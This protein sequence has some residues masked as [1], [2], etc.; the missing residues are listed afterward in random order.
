MRILLFI[1]CACTS[2]GV[3]AQFH[4]LVIDASS[5]QPLAHVRVEIHET[6][7]QVLTDVKGYFVFDAIPPGTYHVHFF[8]EG[9]TPEERHVHVAVSN[10]SIS[11]LRI[12][13]T[14]MHF[15]VQ[16]VVVE[17]R[18]GK[19]EE[20]RS[21]QSVHVFSRDEIQFQNGI[22]LAER[23]AN[24]PGIRAISTG[25]GM[26][27]PQIRAYSGYRNAVYEYGLKHEAQQWGTD[28]GL[29]IDASDVDRL[30]WIKGNA[31]VL[32]GGDAEGGVF[33]VP[34]PT[35][36]S[37]KITLQAG[38]FYRSN[39]QTLGEHV[40]VGFRTA[41]YFSRISASLT[42]FG[43]SRLPASQF[44]YLRRVYPLVDGVL[45][46]T[47][48]VQKHAAITLGKLTKTGR[49][50]VNQSV[51]T[52]E[53]GLFKG[54]VGIPT[55]TDV[56]DDGNRTDID[57]PKVSIRHLK[58]VLNYA[59]TWNKLWFE[60]N[61]GYQDNWR[62]EIIRPLREG[63]NPIPTDSLAHSLHLK[64]VQ[65]NASW[66]KNDDRGGKR[67]GGLA[68]EY[69]N[70]MRGGYDFLLPNYA[71]N[72]ASLFFQSNNNARRFESAIITCG[73]RLEY[74]NW[75]SQAYQYPIYAALD[76]IGF[77]LTRATNA[78]RQFFGWSANYGMRF[79][80]KQ[81]VFRWN[82]S[83]A[84]RAPSAAELFVNGIHH[85]TFRHEVG[86]SQLKAENGV[87]LDLE[88]AVNRT[89]S[90]WQVSPFLHHFQNYIYLEAQP[91]FSQLPAGGQVY[92]YTHDRVSIAGI[93]AQYTWWFNERNEVQV[94]GSAI[95]TYLWSSGLALPFSA[96]AGGQMSWTHAWAKWKNKWTLKSNVSSVSTAYQH[97][98]DR[99][100]KT[101]PGSH[102]WNAS[103]VL[104]GQLRGYVVE[105]FVGGYNLQNRTVY[106]HTS[107]YRRL[108]LPE[109][110]RNLQIQINLK[111]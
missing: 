77:Y 91:L 67:I 94:Q 49:I 22:S 51:F 107:N 37:K 85:G 105:C 104:H 83:R 12:E 6:E 34:T 50:Q 31:N 86:D 20:K 46:N 68:Y 35:V 89:K 79:Q 55:T 45:Q 57:F 93:E 2:V 44:T 43:D 11:T 26:A 38:S 36:P 53:A 3:H 13:M 16:E 102:V 40:A 1:L 19:W 48:G 62:K 52:Q 111:F 70:H 99:N 9:F 63:F 39:N 4:G 32:Y 75:Q 97:R 59:S 78:R 92:A 72:Q 25:V 106:N 74:A 81:H 76:S 65:A 58:T 30:E 61:V 10:D 108:N 96:P 15:N 66:R 17:D 101:T 33:I 21:P 14:A 5:Q 23:L 29:E 110:G 41:K 87:M 60:A 98:V 100:E 71:G 47:A 73:A 56:Q 90:N 8:K 69:L 88:W 7:A 95:Y 54:I 84:W 103:L 18:S 28:H 82:L 64:S 24:T 109:P 80:H 27:K 42:Q